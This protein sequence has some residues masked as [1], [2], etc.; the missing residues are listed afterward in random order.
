VFRVWGV[1]VQRQSTAHVNAMVLPHA[2]E[3]TEEGESLSNSDHTLKASTEEYAPA[4]HSA[5]RDTSFIRG[6]T[7]LGP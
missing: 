3:T 6:R 7:P 5:Y 4:R 1:R 2:W